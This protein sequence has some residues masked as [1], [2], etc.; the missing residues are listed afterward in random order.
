M[1][2]GEVCFDVAKEIHAPIVAGVLGASI[3]ALA[4]FRVEITWRFFKIK[5]KAGGTL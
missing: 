3:K 1:E 4:W 2:W 5:A